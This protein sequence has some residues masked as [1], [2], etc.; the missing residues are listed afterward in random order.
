[1]PI[2][3]Y[4][5]RTLAGRRE[6]QKE[7]K[8]FERSLKQAAAEERRKVYREEKLKNIMA[9]ARKKGEAQAQG[10]SIGSIVRK[11]TSKLDKMENKEN[12]K[13]F[14]D[15]F[16]GISKNKRGEPRSDNNWVSFMGETSQPKKKKKDFIDFI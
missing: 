1:M 3:K 6:K 8:E 2:D 14:L 11:A 9:D 4:I 16:I 5:K 15:D 7:N 13:A 10:R 12:K